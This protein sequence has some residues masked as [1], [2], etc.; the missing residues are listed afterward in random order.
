MQRKKEFDTD[1]K[2]FIKSSRF[3][4]KKK[5]RE[6]KKTLIPSKNSNGPAGCSNFDWRVALEH[7]F[8]NPV[9]SR[10]F[11]GNLL[12][13]IAKSR[14]KVTLAQPRVKRKLRSSMVS[15]LKD[16]AEPSTVPIQWCEEAGKVIQKKPSKTSRFFS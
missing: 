10:K 1:S 8:Q 9:R 13:N 6:K 2:N 16:A 12:R 4:K 7:S 11:I 5:E 15:L 14:L 3:S